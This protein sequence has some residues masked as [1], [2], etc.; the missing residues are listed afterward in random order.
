MRS[1]RTSSTNP[2]QPTGAAR[3]RRSLPRTLAAVALPLALVTGGTTG[4]VASPLTDGAQAPG[5]DAARTAAHHTAEG[6]AL[7]GAAPS[8]GYR[9]S[10]AQGRFLTGAGQAPQA[11]RHIKGAATDFTLLKGKGSDGPTLAGTTLAS[12]STAS[13]RAAW[14]SNSKFVDL[15]WP[16]VRDADRYQVFRDGELIGTTQGTNLRDTRVRPGA[17]SEY[18]IATTAKA[19]ASEWTDSE[20]ATFNRTGEVPV[21]GHTWSLNVQVPQSANT[22]AL[23]TAARSAEAKAKSYHS[24]TIKYR[25]FIRSKWVTAPTGCKYTKGYKYAGDN[26]GF[27][28]AD[29]KSHRTDLTGT[30]YWPQGSSSWSKH[31]GTTHV[32]KTNGKFV[33]KKT[34]SGKKMSFRVMSQNSKSAEVRGITEAG[35]PYCGVGSISGYYNARISRSGDFYISGRHKRMP[36]HEIIISGFTRSP[37][38]TYTKFLHTSKQASPLCLFKPAC[39]AATIGNNG[40]Y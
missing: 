40:G 28:K 34:A 17:A 39:P 30:V 37:M 1:I 38:K 6:S 33:A 23:E 31:I 2:T 5:V 35:N 32:Y 14:A 3:S 13:A 27:S 4:A 18:R 21:N 7:T 19:P 16:G 15:S 11:L 25:T 29:S 8:A 36:D 24:T 26:R 9:F 22:A 12:T 10:A 20:Q